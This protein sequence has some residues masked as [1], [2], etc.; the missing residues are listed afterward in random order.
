MA[1]L[2]KLKRFYKSGW[3]SLIWIPFP[4]NPLRKST[5]V[6]E[7]ADNIHFDIYL[8]HIKTSEVFLFKNKNIRREIL[9]RQFSF[10]AE[11]ARAF[12]FWLGWQLVVNK[13]P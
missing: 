2:N 5:E 6:T 3:F 7:V 12:F 1:F 10:H 13:R 9:H 8:L 4:P 11:F